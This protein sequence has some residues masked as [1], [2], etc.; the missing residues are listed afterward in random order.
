MA[1]RFE[2]QRLTADAFHD[3]LRGAGLSPRTFARTFDVGYD[4]VRR[5]LHPEG[6]PRSVEPP[7]WVLPMLRLCRRPGALD[8]ALEL[9]RENAAPEGD[10]HA[11]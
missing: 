1:R 5:W 11:G 7:Y 2:T 4:Q 9:R 6:H 8:E 10:S 3:E